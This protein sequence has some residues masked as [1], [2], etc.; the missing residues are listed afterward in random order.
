MRRVRRFT[1]G[2]GMC[3]PTV[4]A[5]ASDAQKAA[6]RRPGVCTARKSGASCSRNRRLAL[7]SQA[8]KTRAVRDGDDWVINGQKVWTSGAHYSDWGIILVRTRSGG[9]QAQGPDH[10]LPRHEEPRH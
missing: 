10:V 1:I 6:A 7:T 9:G 4:I 8:L 5:F 3:V 2:L